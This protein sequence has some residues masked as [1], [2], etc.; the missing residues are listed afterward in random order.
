MSIGESPVTQTAEVLTKSALTKLMFVPSAF[1]KGIIKNKVPTR[2][3]KKKPAEIERVGVK[4]FC[5]KNFATRAILKL[6]AL[7]KQEDSTAKGANKG[8]KNSREK[9]FALFRVFCG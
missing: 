6:F 3:T 2:I 4:N 8:K 5:E 9:S 1:E 7:R